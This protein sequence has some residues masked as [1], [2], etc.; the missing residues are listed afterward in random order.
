MGHIAG[1]ELVGAKEVETMVPLQIYS[2]KTLF[3]NLSIYDSTRIELI[4]LHCPP[5]SKIL[6]K[7]LQFLMV[8]LAI[9][10]IKY[11]T[12]FSQP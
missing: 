3:L 11:S 6:I 4:L 1:E 9:N 10:Q 2:S 5:K 12:H 8:Y 7:K